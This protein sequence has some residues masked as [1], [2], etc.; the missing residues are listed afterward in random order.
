MN[1]LS[2]RSGTILAFLAIGLTLGFAVTGMGF[3]L[4]IQ[5]FSVQETLESGNVDLVFSS[6]FTDDDGIVNDVLLDSQDNASSTQLFDAWGPSSSADPAAAGPDT[7]PRYDKD[8]ARCQALLDGSVTQEE[9]YPSYNCTTWFSMQNSGTIPLKVRRIRVNTAS[10]SSN[11]DSLGGVAP[12]D[13]DNSD[14]DDNNATGADAEISASG[15]AVCQ[16]IDPGETVRIAVSGHTL[17]Q[18]PMG[19]SLNY[20][21]DVEAAQ[22]SELATSTD[23]LT[24]L[25]ED[26]L[27]VLRGDGVVLPLGDFPSDEP[28][29]CPIIGTPPPVGDGFATTTFATVGVVEEVFTWSEQPDSFDTPGAMEGIIPVVTFNG[30]DEIAEAPD[31]DL[32]S[33]GNGS[34]DGA[35]SI[36]AWVDIVDTANL[37]EM[38]TRYDNTSGSPQ[39]EWEF[40]ITGADRFALRARDESAG[41]TVDRVSDSPVNQG[42]WAFLVAT[43]DGTGGAS[44]MDGVVLYQDGVAIASTANNSAGYVAM[45]NSTASTGLGHSVGTAG[46]EWFFFEGKMAGGPL[47]PLFVRRELTALEVSKLYDLGAEALGLGP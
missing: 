35:F 16:Q 34:K 26:V 24:H 22:W 18:A 9:A 19:D 21:V 38:L 37:R 31:A 43:Y 46:N 45:E 4:W 13:L 12:V 20:T 40:Q 6:A 8:V 10:G 41:I 42:V 27:R 1:R 11:L 25:Y 28:F 32:W 23:P 3:G 2:A 47:G 15:L 33:P 7:K 17:Q 14:I 29:A 39:R 44:A 5:Q 30:L 36:A